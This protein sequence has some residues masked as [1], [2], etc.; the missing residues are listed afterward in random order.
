[1]SILIV[2]DS[3]VARLHL[4]SQLE[5][6]GHTDTLTADS[7]TAALAALGLL[8]ATASP[9]QN[10]S[11]SGRAEI[12]LVLLDVLMPDMDGVEVCRRIRT[13]DSHRDTPVIMVTAQAES[14]HLKAAFEAGATDYITK[15][16]GEVELLARVRAALTLKRETERR[17]ARE[18]D[19]AEQLER[20]LAAERAL[21]FANARLAEQAGALTDALQRRERAE[22]ELARRSRCEGSLLVARTVAHELNNALSPVVGFADLLRQRPSVSADSSAATFA[23]AIAD[24]GELA[25]RKIQRLQ[26]A[27]SL[28]DPP[29]QVAAGMLVLD[30]ERAA[31]A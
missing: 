13:S 12:E 31:T 4:Q 10:Q 6:G 24:A 19:V 16:A 14:D 22:T 1:V 27:T 11:H 21:T 25:M 9:A 18:R 26:L 30:L 8:S 15:P 28:E 3:A 5:A 2:D 23:A 29:I 7:A 20:A 17:K